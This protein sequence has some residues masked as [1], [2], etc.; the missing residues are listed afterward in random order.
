MSKSILI[1]IESHFCKKTIFFSKERFSSSPK[2]KYP[3]KNFPELEVCSTPELTPRQIKDES[4]FKTDKKTISMITTSNE[5][6]KNTSLIINTSVEIASFTNELK[7]PTNVLINSPNLSPIKENSFNNLSSL[8]VNNNNTTPLKNN[9]KSIIDMD[10]DVGGILKASIIER[11]K[12]NNS[13][14]V[15]NFSFICDNSCYNNKKYS[16]PNTSKNL[17]NFSFNIDNSKKYNSKELSN[18]EMSNSNDF[19]NSSKPFTLTNVFD[20]EITTNQDQ[21][22]GYQ[23]GGTTQFNM[24][25]LTNCHELPNTNQQKIDIIPEE[26]ITTSPPLP[27]YKKPTSLNFKSTKNNQLTSFQIIQEKL[28]CKET[29]TTNL[30]LPSFV[31]LCPLGEYLK[32]L[33]VLRNNQNFSL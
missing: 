7:S 4:A 26:Q 14:N 21:D 19:M 15:D 16:N 11:D 20:N 9:K 6:T 24:M 31:E 8:E 32:F 12:N 17:D 23:T 27:A 29:P 30:N 25:D 13:K 5:E 3:T 33:R 2:F 28:Y 10:I 18:I 22:T 1:L